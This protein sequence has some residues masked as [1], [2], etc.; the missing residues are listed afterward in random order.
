MVGINIKSY[1]GDEW[2]TYIACIFPFGDVEYRIVVKMV[3]GEGIDNTACAKKLCTKV[4]ST[5][6]V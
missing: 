4:S 2:Y 6:G 1:G 3:N 5:V